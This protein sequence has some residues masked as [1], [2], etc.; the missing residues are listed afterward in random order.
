MVTQYV[1]PSHAV[2]YVAQ[3]GCFVE[4]PHT[5]FS[6]P[7]QV[8][9]QLLHGI[10]PFVYMLFNPSLRDGVKQYAAPVRSSFLSLPSSAAPKGT[11]VIPS[12]APAPSQYQSTF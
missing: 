12:K 2:L 10:P 7:I 1:P 9:W 11:T 5:L 8:T 6:I 3:V 4:E